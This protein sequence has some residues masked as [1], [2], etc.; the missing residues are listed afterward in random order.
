[1]SQKTGVSILKV[2]Q[3]R[4]KRVVALDIFK[5]AVTTRTGANRCET[6]KIERRRARTLDP[7]VA[8][9]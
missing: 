1:M 9:A 5:R 3:W 4:A 8:I 6:A 7:Y 2:D